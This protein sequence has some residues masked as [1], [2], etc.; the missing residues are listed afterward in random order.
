MTKETGISQE[1][2]EKIIALLNALFPSV[3]IYLYGSRASG[4][5]R[6]QSDIDIAIDT[7]KPL[8][9]GDLGEARSILE[10]AKIAFKIDLV[11]LKTAAAD[12]KDRILREAIQWQ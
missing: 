2:R 6:P 10:A 3:K 9:I 11:D 1:I 4:I 12:F 7:G 5:F 8:D